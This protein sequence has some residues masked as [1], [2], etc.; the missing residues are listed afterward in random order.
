MLCAVV[1]ASMHLSAA[2]PT[3]TAGASKSR[4]VLEHLMVTHLPRFIPDQ[5]RSLEETVSFL[6]ASPDTLARDLPTLEIAAASSHP[7]GVYEALD[8]MLSGST[9]PDPRVTLL[10]ASEL[11]NLAVGH[12]ESTYHLL[13]NPGVPPPVSSLPPS[14]TLYNLYILDG[15]GRTLAAPPTRRDRARRAMTA[16]GLVLNRRIAR[17]SK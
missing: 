13:K 8:S 7:T 14:V 11:Y 17:A 2:S 3:R 6:L 9:V 15:C 12:W 5:R 16:G 10:R 1:Q 4:R